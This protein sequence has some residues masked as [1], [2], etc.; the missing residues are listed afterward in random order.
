MFVKVE[1]SMVNK[2]KNLWTR[3]TPKEI[4]EVFLD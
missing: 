3:C 4:K 2:L 1:T